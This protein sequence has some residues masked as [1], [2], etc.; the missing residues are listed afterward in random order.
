[1]KIIFVGNISSSTDDSENDSSDKVTIDKWLTTPTNPSNYKFKHIRFRYPHQEKFCYSVK[2]M[3][4]YEYFLL[5][6]EESFMK[7]NYEWMNK[8]VAQ[9]K[10]SSVSI[11]SNI[12]R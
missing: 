12:F 7:R 2:S 10:E 3:A 1:M 9:I 11:K 4:R 6:F 5:F 8:R